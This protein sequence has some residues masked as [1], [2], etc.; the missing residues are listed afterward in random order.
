MD[1]AQRSTRSYM[2]EL[3]TKAEIVK[4]RE[5]GRITA[6]ILRE[7]C[8]KTKPG[9]TPIEL[10]TYAEKRCA[11][12]GVTPAFK[13]YRGFPKTVCI[14]VNNQVVHT[15]PD[16]RP[17]KDTDLVKL[18]FGVIFQGYYGDSARTITLPAAS[19]KDQ[20]LSETTRLALEAGIKAVKV[21]ARL[22]D[23][24]HDIQTVIESAGFK[25]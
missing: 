19:L 7:M 24:G 6:I 18:D 9:V 17:F 16:N 12:L 11:E 15:I 5:A 22:G 13:G 3:K 20:I 10:D 14:S 8:D 23:V 1:L 21:G 2:I 4:M 25:V